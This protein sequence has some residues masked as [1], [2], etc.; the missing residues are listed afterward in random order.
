VDT[1]AVNATIA[2]PFLG[3]TVPI[4]GAPGGPAG[5]TLAEG[6]DAGPV[7]AA[8]VAVSVKV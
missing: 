8:F 5:V 7:P 6:D 3:V 2:C 1:G 4:V